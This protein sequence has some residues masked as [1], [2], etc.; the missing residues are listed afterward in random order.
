MRDACG[1]KEGAMPDNPRYILDVSGNTP[2]RFDTQ[3]GKTWMLVGISVSEM[4]WMPVKEE[5]APES[6]DAK[7]R[8]IAE[9]MQHIQD[10]QTEV[11]D[12]RRRV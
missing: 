10:L 7:E 4:S 8:K 6:T 5:D 1:H 3:N 11:N 2:I 12:L 9:L